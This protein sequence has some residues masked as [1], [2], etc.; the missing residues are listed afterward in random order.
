MRGRL[1]RG[2]RDLFASAGN[3]NTSAPGYPAAYDDV[4][5]VMAVD[6]SRTRA[7]YSNWGSGVELAAPGGNRPSIGR[8]TATRTACSRRSATT[9]ATPAAPV[10]AF[11]QGT[12][13]AS[14][15]AAGV[16]AL[17]LSV[18]PTLTPG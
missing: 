18:D 8:P 3:E 4:I 6:A 14:P 2:G 7:P 10:Y 9:S 15:H 17:M 5:T 1:E 11:Y 16:A 12:S 13:M